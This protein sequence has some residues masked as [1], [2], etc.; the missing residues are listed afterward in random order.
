MTEWKHQ[1]RECKGKVA[2][3]PS[4]EATDIVRRR[5]QQRDQEES[6]YILSKYFSTF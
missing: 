2:Q 3:G 6:E 5:S 4:S 1:V